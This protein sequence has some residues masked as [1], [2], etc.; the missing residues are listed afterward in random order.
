M[1]ELRVDIL[2]S[3][4][5][6][7]KEEW[8][9]L[10]DPND[11]FTDW[12]FLRCLERSDSVGSEAG[13]S[14]CHVLVRN[15]EHLVGAMPLYAKDHSYGEYIFDWAWANASHRSGIPYYPKLVCAVPFTPATSTRTLIR[16]GI[17]PEPVL[18]ALEAG[19]KRIAQD[20]GAM[21]LHV[22]FTTK[23]QL[24]QLEQSWKVMPR[25]TFQFHWTN[26]NWKDFED[27][28]SALRSASRKQIR[29]ERKGVAECGWEIVVKTGNELSDR[30]WESL[31]PLYRSTT[32]A[33]SRFPI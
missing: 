17:D 2:E 31:Y 22:L 33:R 30:E 9:A 5:S 23:S 28:L 8:N 24:D 18:Q 3:L 25:T 10:T 19:W 13:W 4:E 15:Q 20:L 29:K 32:R 26:Q 16:K 1:K 6:V 21:S 7:P 27:Y 14:P 11:P 12:E